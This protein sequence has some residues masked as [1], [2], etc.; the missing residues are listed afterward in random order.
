MSR[1]YVESAVERT[2]RLVRAR[3]VRGPFYVW[4]WSQTRTPSS[5]RRARA[6]QA[7]VPKV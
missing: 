5:R 1:S 4:P 7:R 3:A 2:R 6:S